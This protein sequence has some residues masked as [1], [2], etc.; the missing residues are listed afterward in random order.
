M[1]VFMCCVFACACFNA[2]ACFVCDVLCVVVWFVLVCF[3]WGLRVRVSLCWLQGVCV[4]CLRVIVWCCMNC[5]C[6]VCLC[7][8]ARVRFNLCCLVCM[9]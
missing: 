6:A 2:C 1:Y 7:L 5:C 9:A 4:C 3:C 8:L